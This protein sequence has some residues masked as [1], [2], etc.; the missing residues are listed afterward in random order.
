MP[1]GP[2]EVVVVDVLTVRHVEDRGRA[3]PSRA[4]FIVVQYVK[5]ESSEE[6]FLFWPKHRVVDLNTLGAEMC[7]E[8]KQ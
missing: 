7:P 8:M 3:E 6:F 1:V 5:V 2:Q 4:L